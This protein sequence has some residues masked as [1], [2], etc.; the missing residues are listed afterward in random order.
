[1]DYYEEISILLLTNYPI[2]HK[3]RLIEVENYVKHFMDT[4]T[5][6]A[7]AFTELHAYHLNVSVV[8]AGNRKSLAIGYISSLRP[9]PP[10]MKSHCIGR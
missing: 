5:F 3:T 1:M 4:R 9:L 7:K 6:L 10:N 2:L 8:F